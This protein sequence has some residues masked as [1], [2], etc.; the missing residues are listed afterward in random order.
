MRSIGKW[1][2]T[3]V[4][5]LLLFV[6]AT[7]ARNFHPSSVVKRDIPAAAGE[8]GGPLPDF[9]LPD[10]N[11]NPVTLSDRS[12]WDPKDQARRGNREGSATP[13]HLYSRSK[14]RRPIQSYALG[15]SY[16]AFGRGLA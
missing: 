8:I 1:I 14:W 11:G 10:I 16:L 5:V 7:M 15:L 12:V 3:A 13:D 2:A 4:C 9:T 6:D